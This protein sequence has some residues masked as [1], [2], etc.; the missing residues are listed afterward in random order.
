MLSAEDDGEVREP[1]S[2][3]ACLECARSLH[4]DLGLIDIAVLM[5]VAERPGMSV[6]DLE[7][8]LG[9]ARLTVSR[10]LRAFAG[11]DFPNALPPALGLIELRRSSTN[12]RSL[13]ARL[14]PRG[15]RFVQDLNARIER[16]AQI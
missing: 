5:L 15:E 3:L 2:V 4:S 6:S 10:A 7:S 8:S 16:G 1:N 14:T 12:G 9:V 11:E 13:I